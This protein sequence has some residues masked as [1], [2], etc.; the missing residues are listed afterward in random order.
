MLDPGRHQLLVRWDA[1][2]FDNGITSQF[3]VLG[4]NFWPSRA[5]EFQVNYLIPVHDGSE[6]SDQQILVNFQVAF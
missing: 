3:V 1:L 4:Y 5:F 2:D 6:V